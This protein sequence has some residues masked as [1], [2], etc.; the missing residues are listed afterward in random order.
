MLTRTRI[1]NLRDS[2]VLAIVLDE[3][4]RRG[5]LGKTPDEDEKPSNE[6]NLKLFG[7]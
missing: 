3:L 5:L 6:G 7:L 2:E 1:A 4:Q